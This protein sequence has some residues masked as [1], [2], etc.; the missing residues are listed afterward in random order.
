[1]WTIA[2]VKDLLPP[3]RIRLGTQDTTGQIT[4]CRLPYAMVYVG[5][6]GYPFSWHTI[7]RALNTSRALVVPA[8]PCRGPTG[9][10]CSPSHPEGDR[11][12]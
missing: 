1:M 7:T 10:A 5:E 9:C 6:T 4:G 11:D 8:A 12:G 3:V 2:T